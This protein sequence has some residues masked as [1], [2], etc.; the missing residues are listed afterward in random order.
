VAHLEVEDSLGRRRSAELSADGAFYF[1]LSRA[2]LVHDVTAASLLVY[3]A[4]GALI[5]EVEL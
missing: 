2:D 5:K 3:G 4:D 1:E